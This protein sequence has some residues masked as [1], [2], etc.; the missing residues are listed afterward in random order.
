MTP[1][2]RDLAKHLAENPSEKLFDPDG[3]MGL[4]SDA[5]CFE[6]SAVVGLADT[7]AESML[8]HSHMQRRLAFLPAPV[9]VLDYVKPYGYE[10][11][12]MRSAD[13][14]VETD[15]GRAAKLYCMDSGGFTGCLGKI[16]LQDD[17][18]LSGAEQGV[19]DRDREDDETIFYRHRKAGIYALLAIINSPNFVGRQ[20]HP[21]HKGMQR[22]L[23]HALGGTGRFSLRDWTEIQLE[24]TPPEPAGKDGRASGECFSSGKALHFCRSYLRV[25]GGKLV[26]VSGHWRGDPKLGI[27][28]SYYNVTAGSRAV[29]E[30]SA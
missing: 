23:S 27:V 24:V 29:N 11:I 6:V 8:E 12:P 4:L 19:P 15:E 21:P 16:L 13:I 18:E 22:K 25:Q 5:R 2:I 7:L 28:R 20:E 3:L 9:T 10:N 17:A 30:V 1:T 26:L 14:L